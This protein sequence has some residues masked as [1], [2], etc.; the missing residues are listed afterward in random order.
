MININVIIQNGSWHTLET[1]SA[2]H[3]LC[4]Q[5]SQVVFDGIA[6]IADNQTADKVHKDGLGY[7][8]RHLS[9]DKFHH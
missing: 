1:Y 9:I 7:L 8:H 2:Q 4:H 3:N 6:E 5:V